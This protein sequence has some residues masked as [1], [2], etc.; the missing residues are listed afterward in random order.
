MSGFNLLSDLKG[1]NG[2]LRGALADLGGAKS[3]EMTALGRIVRRSVAKTLSVPGGGAV[4]VGPDRGGHR[5]RPG[6]PPRAQTFRLA[7]SVKAGVVGTGVRVGALRFTADFMESGV[8]AT[9]GASKGTRRRPSGRLRSAGLKKRTIR[10]APRPYLQRA[11]DAVEGQLA[12]EFA[13]VA[14]A[15][16]GHA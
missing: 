6:E 14:G 1:L 13:N 16:I 10:I 5:S 15:R 12:T 7:H 4:A 9:L 8:N 3:P 11:L 2:A